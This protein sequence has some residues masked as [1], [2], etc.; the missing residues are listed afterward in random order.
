MI[1]AAQGVRTRIAELA[2]RFEL[3]L[4]PVTEDTRLWKVELKRE[5]ETDKIHKD[6]FDSVPLEA[7]TYIR[8][9]NF[10]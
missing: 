2:R 8:E 6:L 4:I 1:N 7:A 5:R 3:H 10:Q 9:I